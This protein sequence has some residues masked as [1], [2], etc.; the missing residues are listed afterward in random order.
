MINVYDQLRELLGSAHQ[1]LTQR[2]TTQQ[3]QEPAVLRVLPSVSRESLV[4]EVYLRAL[5]ETRP[6]ES[7]SLPDGFAVC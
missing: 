3:R 1:K 7:V 6:G 5:M 4:V 2:V